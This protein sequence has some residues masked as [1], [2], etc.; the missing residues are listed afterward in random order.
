MLR[1]DVRSD[2]SVAECVS[3]I[4]RRIGGIDVLVNNAGV[5]YLGIAEET[6]LADALAIF[7]T[8]FFG[9]A[10][11]TNAVLPQM[12]ERRR[13]RIINIGSAAAWVGEPGEAFYAASKRA[14]AGYTE[15]LRYEVWPLGIHVSLVEPGAFKTNI[16]AAQPETRGRAIPDYDHVRSAAIRTLQRSL[17]RGGDGTAVADVVLRIAEAPAPRLRYGVGAEARWIPF[18]RILLPQRWFDVLVRRGFGL[19]KDA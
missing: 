1:L 14:L 19:T 2:A 8:N 11:M 13:G 12:R 9:V 3:E 10:R 18:A 5:E 17:Q 15:A 16:L 4:T 6:P 7:E